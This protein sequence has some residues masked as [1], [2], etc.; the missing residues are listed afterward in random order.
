M[1][2]FLSLLTVLM[3]CGV[4][5]F[6]QGRVVSGKVTDPDGKAVSFAT[7][8]IRGSQT[9][10]SADVNGA[11]SIK[12]KDGD[13]LEFSGAGFES[14]R[15]TVRSSE[16]VINVQLRPNV[17]LSE[18]V[19]T[20]MGIKR[21]SKELGYSTTTVKTE[22]LTQ[23]KVTNVATGLAA[24]VSGLQVNLINNGVKADTRITLRGNRSILGNNQALLVVDDVQLPISYISTLNPNDVDNVTVL[25]GASASALYGSEASNGV[26]II[27]TKKGQKG[28]PMIKVSSTASFETIS[29][30]PEFQNEFGPWGGEP[31]N[32]PG[33]VIFPYSPYAPYTPYENQNYGP[34]YNG[35][36]VPI[37]APIRVFRND[38]SFFIAQDSTLYAAKANAKKG[39][40]DQG[41]T[42]TNDVSYSA[43]DDKS[44][45]FFSF[46]DVN[47]KGVLPKDVSRRN[48]IRANGSR[49][50]GIFR[51]DYNVGYTINH[52][53][54]SPGTGVPYSSTS[55]NGGGYTGGGSYFQNR[56][57]YWTV[58]NQPSMVDLRD[59]RNWQKN[60][61]AD[62]D[63]FYNAYYGNPWWQID[64]TRLDERNNDLIANFAL[65]LKPWD[66]LDV[67]YRAGITRNDY[68]NKYT[69]R[70]YT[71]AAWS[72][73]D[74]L[75]AGNIPSGVKKLSPSQGDA[76][77]FN[78]RLSSDL[79]ATIHKTHKNFDF[80]FI[81]GTSLNDN[82]SRVLSASAS[83]LVIPDFF[84]I[85]NRVG[86]PAVTEGFV[87][88]RRVGAFAD[89]T[90][91]YKNY[92]F[93]HGSLRNDWTS[94]L[95]EKNRS[96]L[97]PAIDMAF[98]F[99]DAI[100][101]L[102]NND[103]LSYGKFRAA[104]SRTA[105]VSIGAY[106]LANT[107]NA[108]GGFPFGSV[109]G[110]SVNG[111][112][113]NPNIKPEFSTDKEVGLELG[114]LKNRILLSGA[115]YHTNTNNQTI[116]I[117]I[118][119]ST[120]FTSAVVNSGEMVNKGYEL[121]LKVS[122]IVKTRSGFRWDFGINYSHNDNTVK[123]ITDSL[124][125]VPVGASAFAIVGQPYPVLKTSDWMRDPDGHIIV[126][127]TTGYPTLDP[128]PR[129][130]GA[131][132]PPNKVGVNTSISF[133]GFTLTMVADGRF[134]AVIDNGIGSSLDF[135]GV[136]AYSAQSGRQPFVIP[137]SVYWDGAKY[138]PN[139]NINTQDG[140]LSFWAGTWNT[141]ESNY[142]NSADFWKLREFSL[143]YTVPKKLLNSYI[144]AVSFQV[145]GRNLF[146][147][148]SKD[149][150]WSD[151]EFANN[152]G[153]GTGRTDINQL[154][155]T[156]FIAVSLN[157]T[158]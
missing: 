58:I 103:V 135:T 62:P 146:T 3:L 23:A 43:G 151:P 154:P 116:P 127:K 66:W 123:F 119:S 45:F 12:V 41:L 125:D 106:S 61:F 18:V 143:G 42:W 147:K 122:P 35:L 144:K 113:S 91:G 39:F 21:Q 142:V 24:K 98:V 107:F 65:T 94:L 82:R 71:F 25:K 97:Y 16:N 55:G 140:N 148:K 73:A 28:K 52:I 89:L 81:L 72:I 40:F 2:R 33:N 44:K 84:N 34:R 50:N 96:Y 130:M 48:G 101:G 20:A 124:H 117:T 86:E 74:T 87:Q 7:V 6:A 138:V 22:E 136:S 105:Q 104:Y 139:T 26:I 75:G 9:G 4:F 10:L 157:L 133:K 108:G 49:E 118:S 51:V 145:T 99:T 126:S 121:D 120:G 8:K 141:S 63:G 37:G 36:K 27:T 150:V 131:T 149:N 5:A 77:S 47:I 114:F 17:S 1:R 95:S 88:T 153:N 57:V 129:I 152:T 68:T 60:P 110:F 158:F 78:Q 30:M 128:T 93:L 76:I 13:Q 64:Q 156:K 38:G 59:Y 67:T 92:L 90:V 100:K 31:L 137:N 14:Q 111:S 15:V 69:Q 155:P 32:A 70:G 54:T 115:Y 53:N 19:V 79:L 102:Q 112:F 56:P 109:A 134:G 85:S 80:K 11:Y 132:N 83:V 29:Y 46:Q